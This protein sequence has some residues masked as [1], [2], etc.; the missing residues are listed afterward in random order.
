MERREITGRNQQN[1][2]TGSLLGEGEIRGKK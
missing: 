2:V 1:E